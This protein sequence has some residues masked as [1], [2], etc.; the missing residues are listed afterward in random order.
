MTHT[1]KLA[2]PLHLQGMCVCV[3]VLSFFIFLICNFGWG[4]YPR[5]IAIGVPSR[6]SPV[7]ESKHW[8]ALH[9]D[10]A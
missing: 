6:S 2:V 4:G 3:C 5:R 1:C 7:V 9:Q 10:V 8:F